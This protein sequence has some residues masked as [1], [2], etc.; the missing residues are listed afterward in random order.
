[1]DSLAPTISALPDDEKQAIGTV[2]GSIAQ[3]L[4]QVLEATYAY[5]GVR[6]IVEPAATPLVDKLNARA[7]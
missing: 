3:K 7:I 4:Q 5:P 6:A 2:I 1:L